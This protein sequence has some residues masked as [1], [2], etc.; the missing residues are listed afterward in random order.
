MQIVRVR[1]YREGKIVKMEVD[2]EGYG[3]SA[4]VEDVEA[5][6]SLLS[7]LGADPQLWKRELKKEYY[8]S[9]DTESSSQLVTKQAHK[10]LKK[11]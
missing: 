1:V 2:S 11:D 9:S 6:E 7:S 8:S 4:C 10:S 3:G 5:L